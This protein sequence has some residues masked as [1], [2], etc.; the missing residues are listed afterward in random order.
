MFTYFNLS[1]SKF[2]RP[3]KGQWVAGS[4]A[5]N[6]G[7]QCHKDRYQL[8]Q[9]SLTVARRS[10]MQR[11]RCFQSF[12][13]LLS[14]S[15]STNSGCNKKPTKS[16]SSKNSFHWAAKLFFTQMLMSS[17]WGRIVFSIQRAYLPRF[18][19]FLYSGTLAFILLHSCGVFHVPCL[20]LAIFLF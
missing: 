12:F 9:F 20:A 1:K 17:W 6:F 11:E 10:W 14:N 13:L 8:S 15:F 19:K 16:V 4:A 2:W 3:G 18:V 7:M 5:E